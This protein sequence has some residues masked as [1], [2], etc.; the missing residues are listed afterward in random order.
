MLRV[1]FQAVGLLCLVACLDGCGSSSTEPTVPAAGTVVYK[2]QPLAKG[3]IRF[4]PEKGRPASGNIVDG[5]FTLST[6]GENDGAVPG[7]HKVAL[8][9]TE[10]V[11]AKKKGEEATTKS[12]LPPQYANEGSSGLSVTIPP[13]GKKDI[14][15]KID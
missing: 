10:E 2:G 13:E 4:V 14:E 11:A 5:K 8:T 12:L 3:T 1:E 7:V 6:Y 15:I 9:A